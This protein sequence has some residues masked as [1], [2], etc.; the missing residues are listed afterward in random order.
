MKLKLRASKNDLIAFGC[1]SVFLL[2]IIALCILNVNSLIA[3]G[4]PSG[5]NPFGA[6]MPRYIVPTLGIWVA[7]IATLIGSSSSYFFSISI[8]SLFTL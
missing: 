2:Y 4:V 6:F 1:V 3:N 7:A 8:L 5:L